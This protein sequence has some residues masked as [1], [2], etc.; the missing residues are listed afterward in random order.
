MRY[1]AVRYARTHTFFL[2]RTACLHTT[3]LLAVVGTL[4][5]GAAIYWNPPW[6]F[7][8]IIAVGGLVTIISNWKQDM[9]FKVRVPLYIHLRDGGTV[10]CDVSVL[11]MLI[12]GT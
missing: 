3:Q 10:M 6:L 9:S 12:V 5:A 7:P 2:Q 8:L 4:S 1:R 11:C